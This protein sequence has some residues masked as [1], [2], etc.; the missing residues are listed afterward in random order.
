VPRV[1]AG[2]VRELKPHRGPGRWS[3]RCDRR[4]KHGH[5]CRSCC[6]GVVVGI[7]FSRRW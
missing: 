1:P 6:Y 3:L 4:W 7:R 5:L 2:L